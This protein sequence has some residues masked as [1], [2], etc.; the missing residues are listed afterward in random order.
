MKFVA[1]CFLG[2]LV[3]L[4]AGCCTL[5]GSDA[6]R[7]EGRMASTD[8]YKS[9]VKVSIEAEELGTMIGTAFAID[10]NRFMTAGHFCIEAYELQI[11]GFA[12]GK[13]KM[14]YVNN[15]DELSSIEG[16]EID[17]VDEVSDLCVLKMKRH[18]IKPFKFPK[19]YT[20]KIHDLITIVGSPMG[21]YPFEATGRVIEPISSGY[22][23]DQLN[24]RLIIGAPGTGGVSGGPVVNE[25]GEVIG[26][27]IA[28]TSAFPNILFCSN[29]NSI[30]TFLKQEYNE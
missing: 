7:A 8:Y 27:M 25:K 15:N 2:A 18:G 21:F 29:L 12:K 23:N 24:G 3:V 13:I 5:R 28:G 22:G 30:H 9:T 10:S 4:F 6:A 17:A 11:K 14:T 20:T 19:E 16:L 1:S 26:V